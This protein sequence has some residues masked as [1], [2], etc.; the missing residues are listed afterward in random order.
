MTCPMTSQG[1]GTRHTRG[2]EKGTKSSPIPDD[3]VLTHAHLLSD[4]CLV[5][6]IHSFPSALIVWIFSHF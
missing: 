6:G 4:N 5:L 3:D 2:T 1:E